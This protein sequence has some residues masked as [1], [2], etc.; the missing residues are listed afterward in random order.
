MYQGSDLAGLVC[1]SSL[2]MSAGAMP[3]LRIQ[4]AV[5]GGNTANHIGLTDSGEFA[6]E[7]NHR[8]IEEGW[9]HMV[10]AILKE[11]VCRLV[12]FAIW[13]R[14]FFSREN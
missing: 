6:E 13:K 1:P 14:L 3:I 9:P 8:I 4:V 11:I 5:V 10:I 7:G 12:R 2:P